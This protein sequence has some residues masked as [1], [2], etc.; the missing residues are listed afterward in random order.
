MRPEVEVMMEMTDYEL[1]TKCLQGE[2]ESFAELVS[3]YKKLI[4]SVVYYYIKD[5]EEINDVS[6]E[7]FLRIYKSLASYNPQFKFSTWS[8]RIAT[9]LCLDMIRKRRL[10]SVPIEEIEAV[11]KD[12]DTPEKR[13]L[14]KERSAQIRKAIAELP[15][16]YR[17][18]IILYHQ[19][20]ASYKEMADL[21]NQPM[22]II[23]NRL[24]RARLILRGSMGNAL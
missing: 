15:E 19:K 18:P 5:R 10:N 24:Y 14:G 22:S 21:L 2:Q 23:K 7:V 1:V 12:E 17:T 3:R 16:K 8:V 4:Y 11:S 13:Y 9:N 20:G 6:Q